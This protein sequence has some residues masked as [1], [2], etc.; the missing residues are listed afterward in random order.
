MKTL[1]FKAWHKERQEL[2]YGTKGKDG[3]LIFI[4]PVDIYEDEREE[5]SYRDPNLEIF[6]YTGVEDAWGREIYESDIVE[7]EKG[8]KSEVFYNS[9]T[10]SFEP[11]NRINL[12]KVKIIDSKYKIKI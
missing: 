8:N 12:D 7:D 10:A 9:K 4:K 1:K 5:I 3:G 2:L 11:L 6:Q